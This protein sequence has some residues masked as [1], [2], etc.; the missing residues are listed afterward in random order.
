MPDH[1]R[2]LAARACEVRRRAQ[3]ELTTPESIQRRQA[4]VRSTLWRLIGGMPQR[5]P[6]AL[7]A[8]GS[9]ERDGYR[10]EKLVYESRPGLHVTAN[11]YVP[12]GRPGPF[13]G[14]LFQAGHLPAGKG[15]APYQRCCQALVKLGYLV[16]AFDPAGQGERVY[17]PLP[18]GPATRLGSP[19]EEHDRAGRQLLLAGD[20]QT[21]LMLWD[22]VRSLDVLA[23]RPEV[24]PARLA[25][26]GQSGGGTLTMLLA[27][28]DDRL[29]AAAI[30]CANTEDVACAGFAPPGATDDAEQNLLGAGPLGFDRWD[31]LYPLAP[32][33][34]LV[35]TSTED[36]FTTY[37][38]NYLANGREQAAR[39]AR[40]YAVLGKAD[41][42]RWVESPAPHGLSAD[43]R[44]EIER[45]LGRFLLPE[46]TSLLDEPETLPEAEETTWVF[47]EGNVVRALGGRTPLDLARERVATPARPGADLEALLGVVRPSSGLRAAVLARAHS[48]GCEVETL[49]VQS[50]PRVWVPAWL[51]RPL[52]EPRSVVIA[53]EPDGREQRA[54]R[55][56]AR[57]GHAVC[58]ADLRGTGALR[59]EVDRDAAAYARNHANEE[60]YAWASLILGESLLAQR[61]VD[62]L[63]L[64]EALSNHASLGGCPVTLAARGALTLPALFAAAMEPRI[65]LVFLDGGLASYRSLLDTEDDA[66][67]LANRLPGLL[68]ETDLPAVALAVRPRPVILA[69]PVDGAGRPMLVGEARALYQGA[70]NVRIMPERA[71]GF[72]ALAAVLP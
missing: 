56:L 20:T 58:A 64:V 36:P 62:L 6:L 16:L 32:R 22:A 11:L 31:L 17:Y 60:S 8:R 35:L 61:I 48:R 37:S 28:V 4:W 67:P 3:G 55:A 25:S 40:V 7:Q 21:R 33:P 59:P 63:A 54:W 5:T 68:A 70:P 26:T 18:D 24:D 71:W 13:P 53:L 1:L 14:L 2:S 29:A 9:L 66:C 45:W 49:E 47:P 15:A 43:R 57:A 42:L 65:G 44:L 10:V 38:P 52:R 46:T 30:A 23:S 19:D 12:T 41:H 39:L 27:A 51:F 50:A 34:L 72:E 69:G